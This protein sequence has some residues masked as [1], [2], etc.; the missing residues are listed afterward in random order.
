MSNLFEKITKGSILLWHVNSESELPKRKEIVRL[1]GTENFSCYKAHGHHKNYIRSLGRLKYCLSPDTG[2]EGPGY[3]A[4]IPISHFYFTAERIQANSFFILKYSKICGGSFYVENDDFSKLSKRLHN[5]H[6]ARH[7][8]DEVKRWPEKVEKHKEE[9]QAS[10]IQDSV[11]EDFDVA[12]LKAMTDG[13]GTQAIDHALAKLHDWHDKHYWT[14]QTSQTG[15]TEP[16]VQ[17][18]AA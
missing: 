2:E 1:L 7:L 3:W 8:F 14:G 10:G 5:Y 11:I 18:A 12:N 16:A 17:A 6:H 9:I 4:T 15:A 13:Y